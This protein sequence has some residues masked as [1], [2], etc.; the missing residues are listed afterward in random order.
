LN[1]LMISL[2]NQLCLPEGGSE[3]YGLMYEKTNRNSQ[4]SDKSYIFVTEGS[5]QFLKD[6]FLLI[7]SASPVSFSIAFIYGNTC[8]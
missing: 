3:S 2:S 6:G 8:F 4:T 1:D 5:L 7:V